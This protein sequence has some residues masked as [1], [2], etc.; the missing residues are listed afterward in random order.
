MSSR[1]FQKIREEHGMAYSVYSYPT[2]YGDTGYF[3]L[4]AG[5]G[6]KQGA[7]VT[8]L[9][10]QEVEDILKNGIT[11]EEFARSKQQLKGSYLLGIE[12]T[13]ARSSAI[14]KGE[15]LRGRAE[16]SEELI[17]RIEG[18]TMEDV[19]EIIPYVLDKGRMAGTVV[20]KA[21]RGADEVK[22]VFQGA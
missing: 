15:L 12:S 4:Y 6:E 21:G 20:G 10:L 9:M 13:S 19:M 22:K 8:E 1:L 2:S 11:R 7:R 14:G 5:T 3:A 18:V 17:R 16:E